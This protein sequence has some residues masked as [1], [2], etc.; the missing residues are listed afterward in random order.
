MNNSG[1]MK[2]RVSFDKIAPVSFGTASVE[3]MMAL[4]RGIQEVQKGFCDFES[5]LQRREP[6]LV[7]SSE[8]GCYVFS[9]FG[10][11]LLRFYCS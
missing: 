1:M 9:L 3:I 2:A 11:Q 8:M 7:S 6:S 10:S 5:E 4:V